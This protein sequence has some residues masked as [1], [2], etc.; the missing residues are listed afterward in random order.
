M[1]TPKEVQLYIPYAPSNFCES[2]ANYISSI[3][4]SKYYFI[5]EA[6][7]E[8]EV[9]DILERIGHNYNPERGHLGRY[10]KNTLAL[11]LKDYIVRKHKHTEEFVED[12]YKIIEDVSNMINGIDLSTYPDSVIQAVYKTI[13]GIGSK[14]DLNIIR[15]AFV[16]V[17]KESV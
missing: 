17:D 4:R 3:Y 15:E 6:A 1:I 5:D 9:G 12:T 2:I 10:A 11:K 16:I 13:K 8:I 14:S 7:F